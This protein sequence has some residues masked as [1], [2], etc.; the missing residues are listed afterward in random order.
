MSPAIFL[1]NSP[2]KSKVT[3]YF[4]IFPWWG[5]ETGWASH[6]FH[7]THWLICVASWSPAGSSP[8]L[9][10]PHPP[11]LFQLVCFFLLPSPHPPH[12]KYHLNFIHSLSSACFLCHLQAL[13]SMLLPPRRIPK[14]VHLK[15]TP[16]TFSPSTRF[17]TCSKGT[18]QLL[19][20]LLRPLVVLLQQRA[21]ALNSQP[22]SVAAF[23]TAHRATSYIPSLLTSVWP[24][25]C[26]V[27]H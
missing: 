16:P 20:L 6:L 26:P 18:T 9:P 21:T 14:S 27:F 12:T 8:A 17:P 4:K 13:T 7:H 23:S 2:W 11:L 24:Q 3:C 25:G 5:R 22:V 15:V 1:S 10:H 19:S